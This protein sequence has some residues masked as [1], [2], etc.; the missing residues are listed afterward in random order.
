MVLILGLGL[1]VRVYQLARQGLW[2]DEGYSVTLAGLSPAGIIAGTA[3]DQHPPL[4]YLL[5]HGW[6][7]LVGRSEFAVRFLSVAAGLLSLSVLYALGRRLSSARLGLWSAL[8]L[9]LSPIYI[10]YSQ[11]ARMY[12][13]LALLGLLSVYTLR[14]W[15]EQPS[16]GRGT[17]YVLPTA[18]ALYTHNLA[19]FLLPFEAM[20]A[21][22]WAITRRDSSGYR[23]ALDSQQLG[24][25]FVCQ[26]A[27]A[28]L[29]LPWLPAVVMQAHS[30][31]VP[32]IVPP[33]LPMLL[34]TLLHVSTGIL[35]GRP[36]AI[37]GWLWLA[38]T[39]L[40]VALAWKRSQ[41]RPRA[42]VFSG[43]WFGV[44]A[45][46]IVGLSFVYPLYQDKQFVFLVPALISCLAAGLL[47]LRPQWRIVAVA[48]LLALQAYP[49]YDLYY[50]GSRPEW[51]E[52]IGYMD[53]NARPGD[54]IVLNPAAGE[55]MLDLYAA[56]HWPVVGFPQE[57][58]ILVGGF[59]GEM[60]TP[61][62]LEA[63]LG[64]VL[65]SYERAWL[66]EFTADV[67]DPGRLI[68]TWLETHA[69]PR[70]VP[71]FAHLELRLYE[72]G[73]RR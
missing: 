64:P 57:Y 65:E 16:I 39:G 9:A 46:L 59:V 45:A 62:T 15:L 17:L 5:L 6:L 4:Y 42:L 31:R 29:W 38:V 60:V 19:V 51:R 12:A 11:E 66:L 35:T 52:A 18:A 13:L 44:P 53:D 72:I 7:S 23:P 61:V 10:Q 56:H 58:D 36:P 28:L 55:I 33:T 14:R 71:A 48:G 50:R 24:G 30:H 27:I 67:W 37:L 26:A 68:V 54:V 20:W 3:A 34:D 49:L 22:A 32:W 63:R 25:W 73:R 69:Q 41:K 21:I 2:I 1:T 70:P 47:A 43:L 8:L 40:A